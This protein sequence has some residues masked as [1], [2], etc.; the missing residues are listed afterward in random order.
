[1]PE[2][3]ATPIWPSLNASLNAT[4]AFFLLLGFLAVKQ[5][6]INAH[7][8]CMAIAVLASS[9]FLGCYLY[10]HFNFPAVPF[11]GKGSIRYL[12]FTMLISHIILA[13][14]MLP[15]IFRLLQ[16]ALNARFEEHKR[17]ARIV[18]PVWM[19]TSLTG[20]L[21]YFFLYVWF[22]AEGGSS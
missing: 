6:H 20:I 10:Y 1:M 7:R 21:I 14:A 16:H 19:Y 11:A 2:V 3:I 9:L 4:A 12:Y 8:F 17:L 15:F 13:V 5:K 18:W 22:P